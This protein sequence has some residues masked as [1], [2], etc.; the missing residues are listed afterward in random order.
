MPDI[1]PIGLP[2]AAT[3]LSAADGRS[4]GFLGL[5]PHTQNDALLVRRLTALNAQ[6]FTC[7]STTLGYLPNGDNP[8]QATVASTSDDPLALAAFTSFL[9]RYRRYTSFVATAEPDA[10]PARA[11]RGC[12][13]E[14]VGRMPG[15]VFRS[16]R[17]RDVAI[18]FAS[19]E[20]AC[21][22]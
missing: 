22:R 15:H 4:R 20:T 17:Y 10:E 18:Y 6:V 2:E 19:W 8:R 7:G 1:E 21:G 11:L 3:R 5:D 9:H 13:F 16:G 12:G 14:E